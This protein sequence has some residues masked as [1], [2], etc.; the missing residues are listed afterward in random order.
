MIGAAAERKPSQVCAARCQV[1]RDTRTLF[2][3]A[4]LQA[5]TE[6]STEGI[7]NVEFKD[8]SVPLGRRF[9]S[10]R[11]WMVRAPSA[12]R[13]PAKCRAGIPPFQDL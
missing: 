4:L 8:W 6:G 10:L 3:A 2:R 5:G 12:P 11:V 13:H 1:G 9:R 7:Y